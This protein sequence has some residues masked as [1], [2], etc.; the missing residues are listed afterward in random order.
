MVSGYRRQFAR[1]VQHHID[2]KAHRQFR[3]S[4]E[5]NQNFQYFGVD[6]FLRRLRVKIFAAE[7]LPNPR[8]RPL[9]ALAWK[10]IGRNPRRLPQRNTSDIRLIDIGP[11]A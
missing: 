5:I 8:H 6:A 7:L 11:D 3:V 10:S 1:R 9:K 2:R 4:R